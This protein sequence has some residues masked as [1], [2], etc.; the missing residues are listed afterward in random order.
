M[1][2]LVLLGAP[3]QLTPL[4]ARVA[5]RDEPR[6]DA[7]RIGL[8]AR[9]MT[10][11]RPRG[12]GRNLIDAYR[13][14]P[15]LRPNWEFILYHQR[16]LPDGPRDDR[17]PLPWDYPNVRLRRLDMPGDRFD[18]WFQV[19]LPLAA[20]N[21]RVD[22][23]HLPASAAPAW[24][25]VPVVVT[26]H[27]L[28]PLQIADEMTSEQTVV[29][30]RGVDRALSRARRFI[31]PSAATRELICA[32]YGV[33]RER[34]DV[35]P[36]APD[37]RIV[38]DARQ[39]LSASRRQRI[40]ERYGLAQRW[41]L[42]FSGNARRK[43]ARGVIDAF[44]RVPAAMRRDYQL[45]LVGCEPETCRAALEVEAERAGIS[46]QVRPL[47]F[48]PLEDL[49]VLLRGASG[50]VMPSR[51]EGFGLPI[52]DAFACGVPVL[53]SDISSMPEVAGDAAVYCDPHDPASIANGIEQLLTPETAARLVPRGYEQLAKFSWERTAEAMCAVY[54][55]ATSK[56][57]VAEEDAA[58]AGCVT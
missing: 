18:A 25:P 19:R 38:A 7:M 34:I 28:I 1:P 52:L 13:L 4:L 53:T 3:G 40:R 50:L 37:T 26:I 58:L 54:E 57:G 56:T 46:G 49:P 31:T 22:L 10:M 42:S 41:L 29:F 24:N 27:D 17:G 33:G 35:V 32:R 20:R 45:V 44:A 36:W 47:G 5:L 48:V 11:P 15:S 8:D 9:T 23:L 6:D 16:P 21:D 55:K 39:T 43:N 51:G 2:V 30:A 14:I 12:T